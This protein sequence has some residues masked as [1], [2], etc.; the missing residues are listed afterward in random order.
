[1]PSSSEQLAETTSSTSQAPK[2]KQPLAPDFATDL[3]PD[4]ANPPAG[5]ECIFRHSFTDLPLPQVAI[6]FQ[7][8]NLGYEHPRAIAFADEITPVSFNLH[9]NAHSEEKTNPASDTKMC[10]GAASWL[11]ALPVEQD[12]NVQVGRRS[13]GTAYG[14]GWGEKG[15]GD[16]NEVKVTFSRTFAKAPKVVVWLSALDFS[17]A[18]NWRL[19]AYASDISPEGFTLHADTWGGSILYKTDVSYIAIAADGQDSL[20]VGTFGTEDIRP[21]SSWVNSNQGLVKFEK[22]FKTDKRPRVV[23]GLSAFEVGCGRGF[24]VKMGVECGKDSLDWRLD[25]D[26]DSHLYMA[27]GD[28]LAWDPDVTTLS[29]A[30]GPILSNVSSL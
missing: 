14:G 6:G 3:V 29:G 13:F 4:D 7:N 2:Q 16:K 12:A 18:Y 9:Y 22:P 28:Y 21:S 26:G 25:A 27:K 10:G 19:K 20:R 8:L 1:P 11:R 15:L 5:R 17:K 30:M 23:A 24:R